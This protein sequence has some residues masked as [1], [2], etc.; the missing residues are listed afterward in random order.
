MP[1]SIEEDDG[2][3]SIE[4]EQIHNYKEIKVVEIETPYKEE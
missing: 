2:F 4:E 3:E 1:E